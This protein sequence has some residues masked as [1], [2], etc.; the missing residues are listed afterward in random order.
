MSQDLEFEPGKTFIAKSSFYGPT[1]GNDVEIEP[2]S[3]FHPSNWTGE[4][5]N[6]AKL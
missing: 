3:G 6:D 4:G 2:V 5:E 1:Q